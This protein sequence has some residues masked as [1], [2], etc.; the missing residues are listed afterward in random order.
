MKAGSVNKYVLDTSAVFAYLEDEVGAEQ[1]ESLLEKAE[2]REAEVLMSFV[3]LAEIF[4]ITIQEDSEYTA[5]QRL[6]LIKALSVGIIDSS[7]KISLAAARLK[8]SHKI[9]LADSYIAA[10]AINRKSI[11]VHKDPEFD[12]LGRSLSVLRLPYK[13]ERIIKK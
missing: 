13:K 9:S 4:Y 2:R 11:L 1:V 3:T 7:E 8:A 5:L 10:L 12:C 6:S